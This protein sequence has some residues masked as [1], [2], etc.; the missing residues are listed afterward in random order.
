MDNKYKILLADDEPQNIKIL[1]EAMNPE[2]YRVFV[3]SNGKDAVE[4][5][6]KH[7]PDAIIMD[8]DMPEM[9]GMDAIKIIR[10]T[11]DIK[12]IPIILASGKMTSLTNLRTALETGANDFIRKPYD[13]FEIEARVNSMIRLRME[14]QKFV[15]LEKEIIQHKLDEIT[16]EMEINNQA[17][18]ASKLRLTN[19]KK[20]FEGLIDELNNLRNLDN[21]ESK[22]SIFDII[23]S[24]KTNTASINWKEFE[25]HYD[26]LHPSFFTNLHKQ[27]P[28]LTNNETELCAFI[29]LNMPAKEIMAITYKNDN[30]LKK[31][32]QRLK[33]KFGLATDDSLHSFINEM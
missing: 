14:Q 26:K 1:F 23:S 29:K 8:W 9:D 28:S 33:K 17:L 21:N 13:A 2:I 32:R 12:D 10:A 5:T 30:A 19:N 24:L 18:L 7:H 4:Q 6:I 25:N 31:A 20:Y 11:D 16:R 22:K 27:F 15:V 3:A